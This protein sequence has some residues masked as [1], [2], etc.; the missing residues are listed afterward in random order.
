MAI[1]PRILLPCVTAA[2]LAIVGGC[3]GGPGAES[4]TEEATISGTVTVLGKPATKGQVI[5]DPSNI[6]RPQAPIRTAEIGADGA[7][8]A[9]TLVGS[10]AVTVVVPRPPRPTEGMSPE[11]GLDVQPG[12]N[13]LDI[14]LP[15]T[16]Q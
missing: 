4:S 16:D 11:F 2:C 3:G 5:F 15:M 10:N 7:Y 13:T 9:T 6:N 14:S 1:P 8:R 12:E